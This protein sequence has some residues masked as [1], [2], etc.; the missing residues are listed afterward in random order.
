MVF[1]HCRT[2]LAST[3]LALGL[4]AA[5]TGC[6]GSSGS[7]DSTD[8]AN[9][10]DDSGEPA[11]EL[12]IYAAASLQAVFDDL[13]DRFADDHPQVSVAATVYDGSSTLATQLIGGAPA[14]VFASANE[15]TMQQVLEAQLIDGEPV[16]FALNELVIA[17]APGNPLGIESLADLTEPIENGENGEN[18]ELPLTVSCADEVPCGHTANSLLEAAGVSPRIVSQEQNVTA[19]LA[20][21]LNGEAD[22]GLV[23]RTDVLT[24]DAAAEAVTIDGAAE[25]PN[26]YPIAVVN[27][28]QAPETARDFVDFVVSDEG[29]QVLESYGFGTR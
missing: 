12:T 27:E 23:Y 2:A 18:G 10:A 4:T 28:S 25:H 6:G 5:L 21:V 19:T 24:T 13:T 7:A 3:V 8:P 17:V 16:D 9:P 20:T 22:A 26:R 1:P 14:D 29:Q 11:T 15:P